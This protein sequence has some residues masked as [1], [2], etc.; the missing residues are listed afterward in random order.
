MRSFF[1]TQHTHLHP[2]HRQVL[3]EAFPEAGSGHLQTIGDLQALI[4]DSLER[5]RDAHELSQPCAQCGNKV[6]KPSRCARC[7]A[8]IYCSRECQT[9]HWKQHK[10][11]VL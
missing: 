8:V 5:T 1:T 9:A 2:L 7:K 10:V 4:I 3:G 11:L 6:P